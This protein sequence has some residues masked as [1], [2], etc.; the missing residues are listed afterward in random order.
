MK[1]VLTVLRGAPVRA[2]LPGNIAVKPSHLAVERWATNAPVKSSEP[3][4]FKW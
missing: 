3:R 2:E 4:L 1:S